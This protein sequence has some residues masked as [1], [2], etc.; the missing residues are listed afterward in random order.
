VLLAEGPEGADRWEN[1]RE[2]VAGAAEWSEVVGEDESGTPLERY[3]AEAALVSA[4]DSS[5]GD[6]GV[7]LMTLHTA[8]GLEWPVV[9]LSGLEDGLFPLGRAMES[10]AGLEEERRLFY[11]GLTRA[12][13]KLYL[14]WARARRRGGELR[15]GIASR[16]LESIPPELLEERSTASLWSPRRTSG[17][18]LAPWEV[19]SVPRATP[20]RLYAMDEDQQNQDAPRL[21]KGER[22][23]HRR[24]GSGTVQGLGGAGKDLKVSVLFDDETVG[25]KQLLV[26]FAG[27]E[28]DLGEGGA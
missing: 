16:F 1:V 13:D 8:K 11:V 25:M 23:R 4:A 18:W 6:D 19:T 21:I 26:A 17:G 12:K 14:S 27:L 10:Q 5:Q 20:T 3:L 7:T 9:V 2:L 24:F 15:P 22:V 28:R